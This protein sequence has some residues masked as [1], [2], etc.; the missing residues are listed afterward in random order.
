M[1]K[2]LA[3]EIWSDIACPW[4]YVGKR[5]LEAA[6]AKFEHADEVEITWHSFELDPNAKSRSM[7]EGQAF[8]DKLAK[9]YGMS[10]SFAEERIRQLVETAAAEGLAFRFDKIQPGNTFDAHRL[11]HLGLEQGKQ[12]AVKEAFLSGYLEHGAA[13]GDKADVAK[14]AIDAGLDADAVTAVLEGDRFADAVRADEREARELG[15]SGVPF[16][17]V[18]RYAISGAQ[19]PEVFTRALTLAWNDLAAAPVPLAE[20]AACGP[21]GCAI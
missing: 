6:L 17:V 18:G 9:K 13:I 12:G 16:F 14:I 21:D 5:R 4:C 11:V 1:A 19:P 20:G 2:K 7:P 8:A 15:I 10:V 3:V